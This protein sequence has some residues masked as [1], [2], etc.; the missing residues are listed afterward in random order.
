MA[1]DFAR[2]GSVI[3]LLSFA[4]ALGFGTTVAEPALIEVAEE[5]AEVAAVGRA[6]VDTSAAREAYSEGLRYTVALSVGFA[7]VLG[8]LRILRGWPV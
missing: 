2:K 8:V 6:I 3:W 1:W 4:F 7:L 5:A